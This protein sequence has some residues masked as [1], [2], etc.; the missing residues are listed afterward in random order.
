[1]TGMTFDQFRDWVFMGISSGLASG[2]LYVLWQMKKTLDNLTVQV[3]VMIEK[4][5]NHEKTFE[6]HN[7][8]LERIESA[9]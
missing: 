8:R 7:K 5:K 9:L 3:A 6:S 2:L 1:M 4:D